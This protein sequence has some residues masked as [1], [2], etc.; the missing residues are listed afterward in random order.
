MG[1]SASEVVEEIEKNDDGSVT[2]TVSWAKPDLAEDAGFTREN[3]D[4]PD[5]RQL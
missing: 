4:T 1:A 3:A 5:G 2:V